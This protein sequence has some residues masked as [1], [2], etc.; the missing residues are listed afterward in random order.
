MRVT[1]PIALTWS[2]GA[3]S[4]IV[5]SVTVNLFDAHQVIYREGDTA[6]CLYMVRRGTVAVRKLHKISSVSKW[7][8]H[9]DKQIEPAVEQKPTDVVLRGK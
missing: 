3:R 1:L 4:L 5:R 6:D 7:P 8:A 2:A 9:E